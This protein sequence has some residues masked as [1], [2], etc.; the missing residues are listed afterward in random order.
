MT[1]N[2]V[3]RGL[4]GLAAFAFAA[5][6]FAQADPP[7]KEDDYSLT[8]GVGGGITPSYEGSDN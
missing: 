7:E 3:I 1:R 2:A 6:A 5:P 8:V 4:A